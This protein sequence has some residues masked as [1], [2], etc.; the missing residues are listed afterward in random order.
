MKDKIKTKKYQRNNWIIFASF[1]I[2]YL[3]VLSIIIAYAAFAMN[4]KIETPPFAAS[5]TYPNFFLDKLPLA[6]ATLGL[7]ISAL[8]LMLVPVMILISL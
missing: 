3:I 5:G 1:S 7:S 4:N 8:I 6:T 2:F